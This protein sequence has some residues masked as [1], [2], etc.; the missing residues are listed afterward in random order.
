MLRNAK[1]SWSDLSDV[2]KGNIYKASA[3][4]VVMLMS[5]ILYS[6]LASLGEDLDDDDELV[7][8]KE[9]R[10]LNILTAQSDRLGSEVSTG[11]NPKEWYRM[12]KNPAA[13]FGYLGDLME[14]VG[15]T[16]TFITH[17]GDPEI[18][19]YKKGVHKGQLK[20]WKEWKDL[21]PGFY[22]SNRYDSYETVKT[23]FIK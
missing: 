10:L 21:L 6:I 13:L 18:T 4:M 8:F 7:G 15:A 19:R 3:E 2:Q 1:D 12:A 17:M 14:A 5:Y 20:M 22:I 11:F 16:G 23:F 9:K